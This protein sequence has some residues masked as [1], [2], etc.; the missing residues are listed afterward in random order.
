M[1]NFIA[2]AID[3]VESYFPNYDCHTPAEILADIIHYCRVKDI[4]FDEELRL[5]EGYADAELEMDLI[6]PG[7]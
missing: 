6:V 5:A 2:E 4:D 3:R 7:E 1:N